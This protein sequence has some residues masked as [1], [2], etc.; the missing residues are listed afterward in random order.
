MLGELQR[1]SVARSRALVLRLA[2]RAEP[3]LEL[4]LERLLWHLADRWGVRASDTVVLLL[5]LTRD[6]IS[7]LAGADRSATSRALTRLERRGLVAHQDNGRLALL[8]V[9]PGVDHAA[10]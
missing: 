10:G 3:D 8:G 5:P 9:P 6:L 7:E 4:R 1:R 2:L